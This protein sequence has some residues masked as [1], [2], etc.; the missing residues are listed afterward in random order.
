MAD[1]DCNNLST[2]GPSDNQHM[3][4]I[5]IL[6]RWYRYSTS[7]SSGT[8]LVSLRQNHDVCWVLP[9]IRDNWR[10]GWDSPGTRDKGSQIRDATL[11]ETHEHL[12]R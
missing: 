11:F 4:S 5:V 9:E 1:H 2:A 6:S 7:R 10:P 8:V 12:G 3:G